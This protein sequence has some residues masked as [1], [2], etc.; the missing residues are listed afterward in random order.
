LLRKSLTPPRMN[1]LRAFTEARSPRRQLKNP[2]GG[3]IPWLQAAK[4]TGKDEP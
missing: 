4:K 3:A 1:A 2:A